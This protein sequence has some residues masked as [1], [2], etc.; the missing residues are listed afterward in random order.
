MIKFILKNALH[1]NNPQVCIM[2]NTAQG[3]MRWLNANGF[4]DRWNYLERV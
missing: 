4:Y 1:Y 2:A 3:A